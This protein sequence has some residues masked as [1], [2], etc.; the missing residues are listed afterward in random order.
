[1]LSTIIL[2]IY[3]N[4]FGY[5]FLEL[6][7]D[8]MAPISVISAHASLTYKVSILLFIQQLKYMYN[9]NLKEANI[10]TGPS[11]KNCMFAVLLPIIFEVGR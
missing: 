7:T 8:I 9:I 2:F 3:F 4:L 5:D 10:G 11:L 6:N 1:M